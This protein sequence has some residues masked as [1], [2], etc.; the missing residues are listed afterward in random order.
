MNTTT[1]GLLTG[2]VL[3]AAAAFGGFTAFIIVLA[4]GALGMLVGRVLDGRLGLS[5]LGGR[6][7]DR[8]R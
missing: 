6:G 8:V 1:L 7:S 2:L 4:L 5:N 3:G